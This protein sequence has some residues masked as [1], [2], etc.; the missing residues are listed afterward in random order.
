VTGTPDVSR[1]HVNQS[2]TSVSVVDS[3]VGSVIAAVMDR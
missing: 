1:Y 2:T 3:V